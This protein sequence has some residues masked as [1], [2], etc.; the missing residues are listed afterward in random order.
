MM[1]RDLFS[2][3]G[4][5]PA[6]L[7]W[8]PASAQEP[9]EFV[10]VE[11]RVV[12]GRPGAVTLDRGAEDGLRRGDRVTLRL[13][14]GSSMQGSVTRVEE[15]GAAAELDDL[16]FVAPAGTRVECLVPSARLAA[17]PPQDAPDPQNP[18]ARP[19][20][21][22]GARP[23][24]PPHAPW[25]ERADGWSEG[26][27]LLARVRPLRPLER[28]AST[29]GRLYSI[30]DLAYS[31][32]DERFDGFA[33]FGSSLTMENHLGR[34]ERLEFDGEVN[35]RNTTVPDDD[36]ESVAHLRLDR[37]SYAVGGTRFEADR[38]E[39]GRFL[40]HNLPEFGV[41]DGAEWGRRFTGGDRLALSAGFMPKPEATPDSVDDFQA[42]ASYR[43][44]HD[45]SEQLSAAAGYQKTLHHGSFDRDLFL[46]QVHYLPLGGWTF[47]GTLW[48]DYY[49]GSDANKGKGLE[50]TQAHLSTG[51]RW[52]AGHTLHLVYTH[53]AF[54]EIDR[55]EFLPVTAQQLAD[56]HNDRVSLQTRIA[57]GRKVRTHALVGGWVDQDDQ[58][59]DVQGGLEFEDLFFD[60]TTI[61]VTGFAS[62]AKFLTLVGARASVFRRL[63]GGRAGALYEIANSRLEGFTDAN[64]DLPHHRLRLSYE[65]FL[66]G[67]WSL[68]THLDGMLWDNEHSLGLGF[69]LQK[70]F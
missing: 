14:D 30:F 12:A 8:A 45:E 44:V 16:T 26:Q 5:L 18:L 10:Q 51:K 48:A 43:W 20:A 2:I 41:V 28:R 58:G 38:M 34:G 69:Y 65:A 7:L 25:P 6:V 56:D 33:R 60:A 59:R 40:Q 39:F 63:D 57:L 50:L 4:A 53:M 66:D 29:H 1:P 64:D 17:P 55:D 36:D 22:G 19:P 15:R 32:E 21:A 47:A 27:P 37:A 24:A 42:S 3:L 13:K 54:P 46:A 9:G 52:Q 11:M 68:A 70:S 67:G 35:Y 49:T 61:D 23:A 31:T 62:D